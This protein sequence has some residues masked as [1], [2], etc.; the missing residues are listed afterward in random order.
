MQKKYKLGLVL[1]GG[2][3]R[4]IAHLGV[5]KALYENGLKPDVISGVSAG[6]I[7]GLM[8]ASGLEPRYIFEKI[9]SNGFFNFTKIV[10]PKTGLFSL[11]GLLD[12]LKREVNAETFED[13]QTD[14]WVA[15]SNITKGR[16]EYLNEGP[17]FKTV[18]A[19]SSIPVIFEPVTINGSVY[20][21][22]GL[23]DNLPVEPIKNDCETLIAVNLTPHKTDAVIDS[24]FQVAFRTFHLSIESN[25]IKSKKLC[26]IVIEPDNID[27][28]DLLH[29]KDA[30]KIFEIGYSSAL[31]A[32]EGFERA[33]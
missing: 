3:A 6:S 15:V 12:F 21:D 2:G 4:G 16:V 19:S 29:L 17:L 25:T 1:G 24:L 33:K 9:T 32:I 13:L 20:V 27:N 22:G 8:L 11:E 5:A 14:F 28:Y 30:D 31:K 10:F 26:N 23:F 7:A 18:M